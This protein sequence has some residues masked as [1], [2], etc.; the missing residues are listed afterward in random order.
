M[1]YQYQV[2]RLDQLHEQIVILDRIAIYSEN[3]TQFQ[4]DYLD[5]QLLQN[6][7]Y[8]SQFDEAWLLEKRQDIRYK[9]DSF[10]IFFNRDLTEIS[11]S[12]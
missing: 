2:S 6:Q 7:L 3:I 9:M 1:Q 5:V 4:H 10:Q 11:Q 12:S 8:D